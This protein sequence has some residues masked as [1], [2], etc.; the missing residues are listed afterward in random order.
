MKLLLGMNISP[1][2]VNLLAQAG[3]DAVHWS[4]LGVDNA[5]DTE[6][7]AYARAKN[8]VVLTQDLDFSSI[9]AATHGEK[10]SVA[11]IRG[12]DLSWNAI[13][14]Q[15]V[16]ALLQTVTELE[17][18]ALLTIDTTRIRLR[19]LPLRLGTVAERSA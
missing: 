12:D 5:P 3:I 7:M 4:S 16:A 8:C 17:E 15:V 14:K 13:G 11:Q 10:P 1:D 2:W 9:L 18:G 19:L 6:I